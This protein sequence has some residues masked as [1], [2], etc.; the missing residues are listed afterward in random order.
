MVGTGVA[1]LNS[2]LIKGAEPLEIAHKVQVV[3]LDKT[4]TVTVGVPSVTQVS[5]FL[6]KINI[7]FDKENLVKILKKF[8]ALIGAAESNS[9]HPVARAVSSLV[10]VTI[11][12][13]TLQ[14]IRLTQFVSAP[15][16]GLSCS[17]QTDHQQHFLDVNTTNC[18]SADSNDCVNSSSSSSF[19]SLKIISNESDKVTANL[20]GVNVEFVKCQQDSSWATSNEQQPLN[21]LVGNREWMK[22]HMVSFTTE[23]DY[24]MKRS[25]DSG[26]TVVAVAVNG[27]L[28]GVVSAADQVKEEAALMVSSLLSRGLSVVLLTGDNSRTARAVA[29]K[30]GIQF[31]FSEVLPGHKAS[32]I[33]ELQARGLVVAMVGDGVN[34]CPALAQAD[35]GIAIAN[36]SD[37]AMEA[38]D[39]VLV[40]NDL[41][42][43]V[44]AIDLSSRTVR[45][46]RLNFFFACVY[47][48]VGIPIAAGLLLP[49]GII[50]SPW[51]GSA[52]MAASSLSVLTNSLSLKAY[53][54]PTRKELETSVNRKVT[55]QT[56]GHNVLVHKVS[57]D[58]EHSVDIFDWIEKQAKSG[59][60]SDPMPT[61][62]H[63]PR[64]QSPCDKV[65]MAPLV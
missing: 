18:N 1:A 44:A 15:G 34:D 39:V 9:Q 64:S 4:G 65:E 35:L 20:T 26:C 52:A 23:M 42:D 54:K 25:E 47:N 29:R 22:Q 13:D 31:V 53:A 60:W 57:D 38:A 6:D 14:H 40:R 17:I 55:E 56:R 58:S 28:I 63:W 59:T 37:I 7:N 33:R 43:V 2:I 46:I 51:M 36:G 5:L 41:L 3:I 30:I 50:L 45:K 10:N 21:L 48:L 27:S 49:W 32:K 12:S 8:I 19:P 61:K 24:L 11:G 62:I 16:L